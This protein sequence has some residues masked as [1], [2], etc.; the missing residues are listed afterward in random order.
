[1][2]ISTHVV[3]IVEWV[4]SEDISVFGLELLSLRVKTPLD[5]KNDIWLLYILE[6]SRLS[7]E[8]KI[9]QYISKA[10]N[11]VSSFS[12]PLQDLRSSLSVTLLIVHSAHNLKVCSL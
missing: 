5:I 12:C 2:I 7:F 3:V 9:L 6:T 4:E 11:N 8:P 1:V 10:E